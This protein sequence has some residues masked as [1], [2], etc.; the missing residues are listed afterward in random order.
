M[1]NL[2]K[3]QQQPIQK[4]NIPKTPQHVFFKK[5]DDTNKAN[6]MDAV[7]TAEAQGPVK[8]VKH[9]DELYS[10]TFLDDYFT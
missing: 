5:N 1:M 8:K 3:Q 4:L 10:K 6:A 9:I 2:N 7:E